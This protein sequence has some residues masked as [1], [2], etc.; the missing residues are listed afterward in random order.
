[1][2]AAT[3]KEHLTPT[4]V[5]V[6]ASENSDENYFQMQGDSKPDLCAAGVSRNVVDTERKLAVR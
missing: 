2:V 4:V 1:M 5:A 6:I 3:L